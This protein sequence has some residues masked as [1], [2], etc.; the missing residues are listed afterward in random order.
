MQFIES[1]IAMALHQAAACL[2]GFMLSIPT[3]HSPAKA[4][5]IL[6]EP[7]SEQDQGPNLSEET[8]KYRRRYWG[9]WEFLGSV[10]KKTA[11]GIK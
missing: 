9:L 5:V 10:D 8:V 11:A 1:P 6:A 4:K 7:C 2:S 3:A